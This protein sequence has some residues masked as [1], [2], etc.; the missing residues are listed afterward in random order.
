MCLRNGSLPV[1]LPFHT[2]LMLHCYSSVVSAVDV[3][4]AFRVKGGDFQL[5]PEEWIFRRKVSKKVH[6]YTLL[7]C[8]V[9]FM[10]VRGDK[11]SIEGTA[12]NFRQML[13][14]FKGSKIVNLI[15]KR[16]Q[17]LTEMSF[18]NGGLGSSYSCLL[19]LCGFPFTRFYVSFQSVH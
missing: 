15:V 6:D 2:F 18:L 13:V 9:M 11:M 8:V 12:S 7:V 17:S 19:T 1:L 4:R 5:K 14:E 16:T 10:H 3:R